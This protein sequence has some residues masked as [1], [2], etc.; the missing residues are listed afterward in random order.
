MSRQKGFTIIELLI[1]VMVMAII[2]VIAGSS[3][4]HAR[5]Q[6]VEEKSSGAALAQKAREAPEYTS[7]PPEQVEP[8]SWLFPCTGRAFAGAYWAWRLAYPGVRTSHIVPY[9][10]DA[11][12]TTL[13]ITTDHYYPR[14]RPAQP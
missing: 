3:L 9:A 6:A 11:H 7:C 13:V 14:E 10:A 4:W 12:A 5:Q 2:A 8:D 1:V